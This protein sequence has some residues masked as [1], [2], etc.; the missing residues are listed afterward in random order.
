MILTLRF[1]FN[2]SEIS[3]FTMKNLTFA[4]TVPSRP[5]RPMLKIMAI[6]RKSENTE[7]N[8]N[9]T[10]QYHHSY[11][12]DVIVFNSCRFIGKLSP[13]YFQIQRSNFASSMFF[14]LLK[15]RT[16]QFFF[17]VSRIANMNRDPLTLIKMTFYFVIIYCTQ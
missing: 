4:P 17:T 6:N 8:N 7:N 11:L 12:L 2:L 3:K 13:C 16:I 14:Y 1:N 5:S 15:I 10:S 9:I